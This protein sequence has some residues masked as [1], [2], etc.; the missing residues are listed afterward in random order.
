LILSLDEATGTNKGSGMD[1]SKGE[2]AGA[3][4]GENVSGGAEVASKEEG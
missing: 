2:G 3:G 1:A 4:V